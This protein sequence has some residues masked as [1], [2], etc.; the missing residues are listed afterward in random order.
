MSTK[1]YY[2]YGSGNPLNDK[3]FYIGKGITGC[4]NLR[5][6]V[7]LYSFTV[8]IIISRMVAIIDPLDRIG[9]N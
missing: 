4:G 5:A 7:I 9:L 2:I 1:T 8:S 6:V 3:I